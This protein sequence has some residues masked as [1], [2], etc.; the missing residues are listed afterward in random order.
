MEI[1][2]EGA[3]NPTHRDALVRY[4]AQRVVYSWSSLVPRLP[5]SG[6][7]YI[8]GY[9]PEDTEAMIHGGTPHPEWDDSD[10]H[11]FVANNMNRLAYVV[12]IDH[13]DYE[14]VQRNRADFLIHVPDRKAVPI[15]K[16]E[17]GSDELENL[18]AKY[19]LLGVHADTMSQNAP[20]ALLRAVAAEHGVRV[21]ALGS[22]RSTDLSGL[23]VAAVTTRSWLSPE[24]YGELI[25]WNGNKIKRYASK[26]AERG[27]MRHRSFLANAGWD[28]GALEERD[29]ETMCHLAVAAYRS[30]E[31]HLTRATIETDDEPATSVEGPGGE[32]DTVASNKPANVEPEE[33]Q[34]RMMLPVLENVQRTRP[35]FD[36]Y[37]NQIG[38]EQVNRAGS[39]KKN[40]MMCN[41]CVVNDK[42]PAFKKDADCAYDIPV[43]LET[44]DDL[45]DV[46]R[47]FLEMQT[48]RAMFARFAESLQGGY[49]DPAVSSEFDR[50]FKMVEKMKD[51]NDNRESINIGIQARTEAGVLSRLFGPKAGEAQKQ[52]DQ[53]IDT[54]DAIRALDMGDPR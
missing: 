4:G 45:N 34:E 8:G 5:K 47:G 2:F 9:L 36:D 19:Y 39:R 41:T 7:Y 12:E 37:G 30:W 48:Q 38:V 23:P 40:L 21:L 32:L 51:I 11:E 17:H 3:S 20:R 54:S 18:A 27:L 22:S 42:C 15:W 28:V 43:T 16:P 31:E 35:K 46:M 29:K 6:D 13:E 1:W 33:R 53:T 50:F 25:L 10:Y 24:R 26:Y 14:R 52:L 49:P 44:T